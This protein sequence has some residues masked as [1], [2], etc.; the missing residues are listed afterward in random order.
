MRRSALL[1]VLCVGVVAAGCSSGG[2]DDAGRPPPDVTMYEGLGAWVDVYDYAPAFQTD[3]T[4]PDVIPEAVDDMDALGVETLYLQAAF[5]DPNAPD[6]GVV[7][8]ELVGEFLERAHEHE[9][10]VVAWYLPRLGDL[11]VDLRLIEAMHDF[12]AGDERFD[13]LALDVEWIADVP[14]HGSRNEAL[15]ELSERA[16]ETVGDQALGAIV[17][18]PVQLE[19][20]NPAL[21]PGFP[22]RELAPHY[23]AWLPMAYYTFCEGEHRD[24]VRYVGESVRRL[25]A[26]LDDEAA[27]VHAIGGIADVTT[28][29]DVEGLLRVVDDEGLI[30][31]SL[32]D[33]DTTPTPLWTRLRG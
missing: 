29:V 10:R 24:A 6:D 1:V 30:G 5:A 26:N 7:D 2:D 15:V 9:I 13:S 33:Y 18:P 27:P 32:Y 4:P 16:R 12:E 22:W 14:D 31:W 21:W 23:D 3:G 17:L 20:V 19:V 11:E 25:R 8:A 28:T